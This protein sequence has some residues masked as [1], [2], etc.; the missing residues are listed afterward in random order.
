VAQGI[1]YA[2]DIP[3]IA[4]STLQAVAARAERERGFHRVLAVLGARRNE[5]YW[6]A[7]EDN[8]ALTPERASDAAHVVLPDSGEWCLCGP[9]AKDLGAFAQSVKA[10]LT[11]VEPELFP[12]AWDVA[13]LG[14]VRLAE[15]ESVAAH[16]LEP[17]YL[18]S[19]GGWITKEQ[20]RD[21][22]A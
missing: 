16:A 1:A 7:Y 14:A 6:G 9:G 22:N 15:G 3:A 13:T 2:M 19:R 12:A 17:I 11:A 10:Q 4:V 18:S 20:Q 21:S 5:V 8:R